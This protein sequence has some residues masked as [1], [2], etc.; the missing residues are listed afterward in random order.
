M[1]VMSSKNVLSTYISMHV[2]IYACMHACMLW[3][4][5]GH[6][7]RFHV[8]AGTTRSCIGNHLPCWFKG[9]PN[10]STLFAVS[11]AA[12]S[13]NGTN[14]GE[15]SCTGHVQGRYRRGIGQWVRGKEVSSFQVARYARQCCNSRSEEDWCFHRSRLGSV[16]D[17]HKAS[18]ESREK[19]GLR[20]SCHGEGKTSTEDCE[21]VSRRR[22]EG[23]H[24]KKKCGNEVFSRSIDRGASRGMI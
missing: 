9:Y 19:G 18:H 3:R 4:T 1:Y 24:L 10:I 23:E 12:L 16:E 22:F 13:R 21:S 6:C 7:L 2:S 5:W 17:S 15:S 14:E 11:F 8:K 20:Q